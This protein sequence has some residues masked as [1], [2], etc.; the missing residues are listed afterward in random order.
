M[1]VVVGVS[2]GADSVCLLHALY[3]LAPEWQLSLHVAHVDHGLRTDSPADAAFVATL[4]DTLGLP[5]HL[6]TIECADLARQ[7]GGIEAA[8]RSARYRFLRA[9]A[10]NVA[11][12]GQVPLVGVGHHAD[13]QAETVLMHLVQG[14]GLRGLGGMRWVTELPVDEASSRGLV[15][16]SESAVQLV[17]PLLGV[18]RAAILAYLRRHALKWRDDVTNQETDRLRNRLRHLILPALTAINANIVETLGNT[19][20]ILAGETDRIEMLDQEL[21]RRLAT[22]PTTPERVVL[23]LAA[24][25]DLAPADQRG[26]LRAAIA[27]LTM[28][29]RELGFA[30]VEALLNRSAAAATATGPHPLAAGIAWTVAGATRVHPVRLSLHQADALPFAPDHP[31][32]DATW[33]Q[34]VGHSHLPETGKIIVGKWQ[35]ISTVGAPAPA[36]LNGP[37][38]CGVDKDEISA[39]GSRPSPLAP[40]PY[41]LDSETSEGWRICLDADCAAELCLTTPAPGMRIAPL[42]M[43]GHHKRLGDLFTDCKIPAALRAGWPIIL[44]R[45]SGHVIWVCGIR[46]A[47]E[48]RVTETTQRVRCLEW[49]KIDVE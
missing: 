7:E 24:W 41:F 49:K 29:T 47:H 19:A 10:I 40:R 21:L 38:A 14:S 20:A 3:T 26:V 13:D 34:T 6:A 31:F 5:F 12:A 18:R 22:E 45:G 30:H 42:G 25:A 27:L 33:R 46:M 9:T 16:G 2:G 11:P 17:R 37:H 48:L 36:F 8:A 28:D 35:L 4:A 44:D 23:S 1:T 15:L 32:L 43:A 39:A